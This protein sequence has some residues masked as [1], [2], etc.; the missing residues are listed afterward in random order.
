[1]RFTIYV[2]ENSPLENLLKSVDE[3]YITLL[4]NNESVYFILDSSE[5][6]LHSG[7]NIIDS[8]DITGMRVVRINRKKFVELLTQGKI[9]FTFIDNKIKIDFHNDVLYAYSLTVNYQEELFE[10]YMNSIQLFVTADQYPK[11]KLSN[12]GN[13]VRIAKTLGSTVTCSDNVLQVNVRDGVFIYKEFEGPDFTINSALLQMILRYSLELRNVN[14]YLVYQNE[15]TCVAV[16][17]T[18]LQPGFDLDYVTKQPSSHK[19]RFKMTHMLTLGKKLRLV[20]GDL[21]LNM[22]KHTVTYR[23]KFSSTTTNIE[24][25][26]KVSAKDKKTETKGITLNL[27]KTSPV[28]VSKYPTIK[29]PHVVVKS[30][31]KNLQTNDVITLYVKKQ[32]I[33]IDCDGVKIVFRKVEEDGE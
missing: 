24:V 30:I 18:G 10:K 17:K 3:E 31:L 4:I 20:D 11:I 25:L 27:G 16:R 5:Y 1:M 7:F 2:N 21:L 9:I 26:E 29:I 6:Y 19:V 13:I 32:F 28:K 15:G 14:N 33:L 23:E 8:S 22:D 12:V